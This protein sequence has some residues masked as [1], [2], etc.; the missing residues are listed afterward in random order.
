V[1]GDIPYHTVILM[2]ENQEIRIII[3]ILYKFINNY[4]QPIILSVNICWYADN[5]DIIDYSNPYNKSK[6]NIIKDTS[7]FP[8]V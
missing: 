2:I 6:I 5:T 7:V 1:V 3:N 8:S 4:I